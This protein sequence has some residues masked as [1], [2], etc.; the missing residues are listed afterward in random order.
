MLETGC[1]KAGRKCRFPGAKQARA[2]LLGAFLQ[3]N[4]Q[5]AG[6]ERAS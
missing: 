3:G 1:I 6:N 2:N 5:T 4:P